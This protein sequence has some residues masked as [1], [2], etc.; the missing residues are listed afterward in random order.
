MHPPSLVV[1]LES[2]LAEYI[3]V[4]ASAQDVVLAGLRWEAPYWPELAVGWLEQGLPIDVEIASCLESIVERTKW[5][6]P[7][8]H[9]AQALLTVWRAKQDAGYF[10]VETI[11]ANGVV[12]GRNAYSDI[13]VGA[14]FI[15]LR[16]TKLV[17]DLGNFQSIELGEIAQV[18]LQLD[19]V[20]W[21]HRFIDIVPRGHSAGLYLSGTG[22]DV[23]A[24]A[25]RGCE[26]G[27]YVSLHLP[28]TC[29]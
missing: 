27:E 4:E 2:S 24:D 21:F 20:K 23:L 25:L 18:A 17:G 22:L 3:A 6:Q 14:T 28:E 10:Q 26:K 19:K 16:K 7:L 1:H 12:V 9:R 15:S 29:R 5:P 13:P 11:L 8:R